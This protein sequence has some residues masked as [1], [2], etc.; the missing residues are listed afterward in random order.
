MP[1]DCHG[2]LPTKIGDLRVAKVGP[3]GNAD[4]GLHPELA[5]LLLCEGASPVARTNSRTRR[6]CVHAAQVVALTT[7]TVVEE[8]SAAVL[9]LNGAEP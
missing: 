7:T 5:G 8:R 2:F 9:P 3:G 1:W 6:R 4:V